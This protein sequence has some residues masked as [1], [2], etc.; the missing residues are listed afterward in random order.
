MPESEAFL[1]LVGTVYDAALDPARWPDALRKLA[2]FA[3]GS[4]AAIYAK[5]PAVGS[6]IVYHQFGTDCHYRKLYFDRYVKIDPSTMTQYF[7]DIGQQVAVAD[8]MPYEEFV[9]TQFFREW[10][11]P[12]GIVDAISVTL[13]KSASNVALFGVFRYER[14]GIVDD[15]MRQRMALVFPHVRRAI[16]IGDVLNSGSAEASA[17]AETLNGLDASVYLVNRNAGI[18]FAN[19]AG[20]I[21]LREGNVVGTEDDVLKVAD[22]EAEA[23]L[24]S[25]IGAAADGDDAIGT[26]GIAIPLTGKDGNRYVAH[27]LPLTSG[28]RRTA[29]AAFAA[30]VALFIRRTALPASSAPQV[31]ARAFGL[32]PTELR[33]LL[34]VVEVD[35]ISKV[36]ENLG[37]SP[38][39]VKTHLSR[40]FQKT[41][42]ARQADLVRLVEGYST[43]LRPMP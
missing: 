4:A 2:E 28:A 41:G 36:A 11:R 22:R 40:V 16:L 12:Q 38:S 20:Q 39:T 42:V 26:K 10:C 13:E 3:G 19:T 24:R 30:A 29:G 35:G 34:A 8:I 32:T 31:M 17:F 9:D 27:A 5:S 7:A 1:D 33:V 25:V 18:V 14:E 43:P 6:G 23:V 37:M 21:M 15:A